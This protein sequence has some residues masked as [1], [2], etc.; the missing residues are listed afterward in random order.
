[1][2]HSFGKWS[3]GVVNRTVFMSYMGTSWPISLNRSTI[4][5]YCLAI[6]FVHEK[7]DS[8]EVG[9]NLM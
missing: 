8:Y 9:Q 7:I 4:N 1:M 3:A 2:T 6:S 5:S